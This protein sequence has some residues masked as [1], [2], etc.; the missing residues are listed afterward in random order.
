MKVGIII[1]RVTC[2]IV[3]ITGMQLCYAEYVYYPSLNRYCVPYLGCGQGHAIESCKS[4]FTRDACVVCSAG[5]VQP[6]VISSTADPNTTSCFKPTSPCF[7]EELTYS[8]TPVKAFCTSLSGCKC[9]TAKCYFGDPCLCLKGNECGIGQFMNDKG[10]CSPCPKGTEKNT[11]GCG[12]CRAIRNTI[13]SSMLTTT[14]QSSTGKRTYPSN[15]E[16]NK[17][18]RLASRDINKEN[19]KHY[20]LLV[21]VLA[22]TITLAVPMVY[23]LVLHYRRRH[24]KYYWC[25]CFSKDNRRTNS[26]ES[27]DMML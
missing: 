25:N 10:E 21:V 2:A 4:N 8:R 24:H 11:T 16:Y 22:I 17:P 19:S 14:V 9:N 12:P 15:L 18:V 5:Y 6:D 3:T 13:Q 26:S 20:E 27:T 7:S 1:C 23:I